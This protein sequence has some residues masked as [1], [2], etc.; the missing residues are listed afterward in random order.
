MPSVRRTGFQ[1]RSP[2][3]LIEGS[4]STRR[5]VQRS[6]I[7]ATLAEPRGAR[8]KPRPG[9]NLCGAP[10]VERASGE[11][12]TRRGDPRRARQARRDDRLRGARTHAPGNRVPGRPRRRGRS[13]RRGGGRPGRLRQGLPGAGP[14]P[15]GIALPAVAAADRRERGAKS[16]PVGG[17]T[18]RA[19][20]ARG[21]GGLG[22]RGSVPRD[23]RPH[24][25]APRHAPRRPRGARRARPRGARPPLSP[26]ARRGGDGGRARHPSRHGQVADVPRSR[27][28]AS[29]G[30][31]GGRVNGLERELAALSDAVEWPDVPDLAPVVAG[32]LGEAPRRPGLARRPLAIAVAVVLAAVLAVLAVP[33]ARTAILDWLGIGGAR[34]VRVDELPPLPA[35]RDFDVLGHRTSSVAAQAG[36]GFPLAEPPR[37]EPAPDEVRLAPG[38]RVSY[39]WRDGDHVRLL[40]TQFPGRVGD[41]ALLKKLVG[42]TTAVDRFEVD[43]DPA[44][45]LEG[46][47]HAVLFVAPD[48]TIRDDQGWLAGN[49]L[50]VD[51]DGVTIRVE[52]QL[53]REDAVEL[54][55][56]TRGR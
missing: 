3:T 9:G 20:P 32:R 25:G 19:R 37:D 36:A 33:P 35:R 56:A 6:F 10:G 44:V 50:L 34:I 2:A 31:G 15:R 18:G 49:T 22:G 38:L 54:V 53:E 43:G 55:R 17:S 28:A 5:L 27:S 8:L 30:G 48:G 7:T 51:R 14:V 40:I 45:W 52:G 24:V 42:R 16:A 13:R 41:P 21:G 23:D 11:P 29:R 1:R 12:A 39:I 47:P 4:S 46:G 26:R